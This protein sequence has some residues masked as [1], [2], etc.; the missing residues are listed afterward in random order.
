MRKG[1]WEKDQ[2]KN[3]EWHVCVRKARDVAGMLA[4]VK[5][6]DTDDRDWAP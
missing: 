5:A 3:S 2:C 6:E 4:V 1:F